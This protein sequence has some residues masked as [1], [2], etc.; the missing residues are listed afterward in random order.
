MTDQIANDMVLID[1]NVVSFIFKKDSRGI[2]YEPHLKGRLTAIAAQTYAEL[3]LLP[4]RNNSSASRHD[5]FREYIDSEFIFLEV[6]RETSLRWSEIQF[7]AKRSG[8]PVGVADA[9][10]AATAL[11]Y[12]IPLVTHNSKDFKDISDLLIITENDNLSI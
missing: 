9:W 1:T 11:T 10:I 8:R 5:R 4:L 2:Q 3:N 12:S 7:Q 6:S